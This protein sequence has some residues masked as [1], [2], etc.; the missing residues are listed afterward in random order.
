MQHFEK[1]L[2]VVLDKIEL[3]LDILKAIIEFLAYS[4]DTR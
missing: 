4:A 3:K 2:G 1:E